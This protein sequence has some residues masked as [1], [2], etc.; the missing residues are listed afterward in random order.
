V[1]ER[2]RFRV[3]FP[4]QILAG[5]QARIAMAHNSSGAGMLAAVS[6]AIAVGDPVVLRFQL[7]NSE[8]EHELS[9]RVLR[10][11]ENTEDPQGAWPQ[12]VAIAFDAVSP[13]L[14]PYLND[15]A[16]RFGPV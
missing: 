7:P 5:K 15:A 14:E 1:R 10:L 6:S 12:R 2:E 16:Q 3:W 11:E 8:R 9:G 4:V 13:E